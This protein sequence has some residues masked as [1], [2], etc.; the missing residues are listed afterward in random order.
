MNGLSCLLQRLHF[1]VS[2]SLSLPP[3]QALIDGQPMAGFV[4]TGGTRLYNVLVQDP[5]KSHPLAI[6]IT[7]NDGGIVTLYV[8]LT[9]ATS[10]TAGT[11]LWSTADA[12]SGG[13]IRRNAL[14]IDP[15]DANMCFNCTYFVAVYGNTIAEY[16]LVASTT[17]TLLVSGEPYARAFDGG[18]WLVVV[19]GGG[20]CC[21][22]CCC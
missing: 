12:N 21:G 2:L 22:Y 19:G 13:A 14:S 5:T 7:P 11:Y 18:R 6:T 8:G 17:I 3:T 15:S 4:S 1:H 10:N 20:G 9:D 16:S